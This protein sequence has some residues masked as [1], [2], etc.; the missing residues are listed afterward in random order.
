MT[1]S[2]PHDYTG[3]TAQ[4]P[5]PV[6]RPI[7]NP[8]TVA[9]L[10]AS[11]TDPRLVA[12]C[13]RWAIATQC[14]LGIFVCFTALL[15]FGAAYYTLSTLKAPGAWVLWIAIGYSIFIG[16]LDREIVGGLDK[17]TAIVRPVLSLFIG[18]I[19]AIPIELWV[20]QDRIDQDLQRQYR[21]DNREQLDQLRTEQS[22]IEQ[23]RTDLQDQLAD[24]RK[25]EAD[26]GKAMDDELVGRNK[27]GRSGVA[28][29]GPVFE[30]AK[31]QQADV[32]QRIE[33]VRRDFDRLERSMPDDQQRV[34]R[35]FQREEIGRVTDFVTRYEALDRVVH[36]SAPLYRLSWVIRLTLILI[37]MT[38]A[39]LKLLTPHVDYHHLV[40][41][42]IRENVARI[43]EIADRNY[44]LAMDHPER[45]E[46]S[47]SEK[48]AIVR[49]AP[50]SSAS[51]LG[52]ES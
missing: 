51:S 46:L 13:S 26:W 37:E 14:A 11:K 43:D 23:R 35:H 20:F 52:R 24:L 3:P 48:F 18:T 41:A 8:V 19:I 40:N 9:L 30:N 49:Y 6:P 15:A 22:Q 32:R 10:W 28:G 34:E 25:Q 12:V 47:V 1:A 5:R 29:A 21:R 2:I 31:T 4:R 38:P 45:P 44:R 42:E 33:E 27:S 17:M 7:R 50:V 39:L 36:S 16:V